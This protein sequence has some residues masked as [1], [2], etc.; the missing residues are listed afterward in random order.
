MLHNISA[1]DIFLHVRVIIGIVLGLS[2][3]RLLTGTARFVQHPGKYKLYFV[4]LGWVAWMLLMLMHFWWW[5]LWLQIITTWTFATY[6]L[7]IL[8]AILLF[9][10]CTLLFPDDI[11]EYSGYEAFFISRRRWFFGILALVFVF[12]LIDTL[13]KGREHF[14]AFGNE[15]LIRVP[16]YIVLC[17]IAMV[18]ANRR[19]H[20]A[21]VIGS[22][23]YEVSWILRQFNTL[24]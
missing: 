12:D 23:L 5:E 15:Y 8:Y 24:N 1:T 19:Y 11:S 20:A 9:A 14:D 2:M 21:L 16:V 6:F 18:T 22:L 13:L 4:H 17:V 7:L 3:T 10:L